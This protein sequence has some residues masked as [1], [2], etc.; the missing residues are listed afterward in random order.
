MIG[1]ALFISCKT[2][3]HYASYDDYPVYNGNDLELIYSPQVSKFRIWA[4]TAD[5]VRILLYDHGSDGGAYETVGMKRSEDGTWKKDIE[6]NLK[7]KFYTFQVRIGERWLDETPGMWVKAVGLNGKRAAIIDLGETNPDGW[8]MDRRPAMKNFT[9]III[10]ETH[11]RDFSVSSASGMKNKGKYLAFTEH[12]TKNSSGVSTGIDH[13]KELGITHVQLMPVSDFASVDESRLQENK[14]SWG[15]DTQNFNVPEG[16]YSTNPSDPK[17][18]IRELKQM[19]LALHKSDIGVIL[20]MAYNQTS[21]MPKSNPDLLAPGYFYRQYAD[22]SRANGSGYANET[23]SERL[24]MRKFM[25]ES[26][27]YWATEYHIDGFCF[28]KMGLHDVETMN[29]IRAALDKVDPGILMYVDDEI[30]GNSPLDAKKRADKNNLNQ[31]DRIALF[32]ND[33]RDALLGKDSLPGFVWGTDSLEENIKY[34]VAGSVKHDSVNY[35]RL[36]FFKQ[37]FAN[38]PIQTINFASWHGGWCL[39]DKIKATAPYGASENDIIRLHKLIQTVVFTS[40]GIPFIYGGEELLR[41]KRGMS[42]SEQASDSVNAIDWNNKSKYADLFDYYKGLAEL[43]KHHG[44]FRIPTA[45]L[46]RTNLEFIHTDFRNVVAYQLKN[47]V[48]G[49]IWKNVL[50]LLNG[51]RYPVSVKIPDGDWTVVCHDGKIDLKGITTAGFGYFTVAASSASI[52]Y[53]E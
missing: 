5:E 26:V 20:N 35:S 11:V 32:G 41:D 19:V 4:P 23:A 39:A 29:E 3:H 42:S 18:R 15:Y 51:N 2:D 49:E 7:G 13:L 44:A 38:A 1:F 43:R 27:V 9:D 46:I 30:P 10:Y 50:V 22:S 6:G 37:P 16:S 40:Q 28:E 8:E 21:E 36:P 34:V 48:N 31:L 12:G 33:M 14:Y 24:M 52:L 45:D 25:V 53:Q 47:H 17:S